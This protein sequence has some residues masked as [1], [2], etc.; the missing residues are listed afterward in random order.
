MGDKPYD[1]NINPVE[2]SMVS[3]FTLG[4]GYHNFHHAFP[5]DYRAADIG[6]F[7]SSRVFIEKM[8][9]WGLANDLKVAS[10]TVIEGKQMRHNLM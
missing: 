8:H 4:E 5:Y 3:I 10:K 6:V 9:E 7:N 1:P 2:N